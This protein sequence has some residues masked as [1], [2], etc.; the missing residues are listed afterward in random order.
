MR[1]KVFRAPPA[2]PA[3]EYIGEV[4]RM[5]AKANR[6]AT[7]EKMKQALTNVCVAERLIHISV[8]EP[9][10]PPAAEPAAEGGAPADKAKPAP[11]GGPS[12]GMR[13][14]RMG[15]KRPSRGMSICRKVKDDEAKAAYKTA[16]DGVTGL[17]TGKRGVAVAFAQRACELGKSLGAAARCDLPRRID[18]KV[19]AD[20]KLLKDKVGTAEKEV[21]PV[22]AAPA[23]VATAATEATAATTE[24]AATD[25][26]EETETKAEETAVAVEDKAAEKATDAPATPS[27]DAP[28]TDA[29]ATDTPAAEPETKTSTPA[30]A[31]LPICVPCTPAAGASE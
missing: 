24:V 9:P 18:P 12:H 21:K 1:R 28:A 31:P 15:H 13:A 26:K 2:A 7:D 10:P 3:V 29:P 6:K 4:V 19:V 17:T 11:H 20:V 30:A 23:E 14:R 25:A 27:T 16:T 8:E 5:L 22:E